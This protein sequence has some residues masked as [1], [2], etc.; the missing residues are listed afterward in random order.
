MKN[1][2]TTTNPT[3]TTA[4]NPSTQTP[5]GVSAR[6]SDLLGCMKYSRDGGLNTPDNAWHD[7]HFYCKAVEVIVTLPDGKPLPLGRNPYE[8]FRHSVAKKWR[9]N[10]DWLP[11][12]VHIPQECEE[13]ESVVSETLFKCLAD[14]AEQG[15]IVNECYKALDAHYGRY[16]QD[17]H[18]TLEREEIEWAPERAFIATLFTADLATVGGTDADLSPD[19]EFGALS[20]E[21]RAELKRLAA[22]F[23]KVKEAHRTAPREVWLAAQCYALGMPTETGINTVYGVEVAK[24]AKSAPKTAKRILNSCRVKY[25]RYAKQVFGWLLDE[26]KEHPKGME[27]WVVVLDYCE[28]IAEA[29]AALEEC[30]VKCCLDDKIVKTLRSELAHRPKQVLRYCKAVTEATVSA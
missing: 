3:T 24:A 7:D 8:Q 17:A 30:A 4:T 20:A 16:A 5:L 9:L 26:V 23:D 29:T 14:G 21:G 12:R 11:D 28:A 2:T 27:R 13:Q 18:K 25:C 6:Y 15:T 22:F 1:A 19:C 10:R